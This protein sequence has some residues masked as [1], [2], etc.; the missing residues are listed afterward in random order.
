MLFQSQEMELKDSLQG[1]V[2]YDAWFTIIYQ[3][4]ANMTAY[5]NILSINNA[6][7][8]LV[9]DIKFNKMDQMVDEIN[10][11]EITIYSSTLS[12]MPYF[13]IS[14]CDD[15]GKN[16]DIKGFLSDYMD[17]ICRI[18][19]CTWTSHA[20]PDGSWGVRPISGPFNKSGVWGG[21]MGNVV[22]KNIFI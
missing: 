12:W 7:K 20:P 18:I 4:P 10:M 8:T 16:C 15:M 3:K 1:L 17:A 11:E 14:N 2:T 9:Q 19:N 6:T 21:A 22:I 13:S 5:K